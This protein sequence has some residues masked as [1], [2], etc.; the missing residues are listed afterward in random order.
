[1]VWWDPPYVKFVYINAG[2]ILTSILT[3]NIVVI[4]IG[5]GG[6]Y[7]ISSGTLNIAITLTVYGDTTLAISLQMNSYAQGLGMIILVPY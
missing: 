4:N 1:M 6:T 7:L 5:Y 2:P 3:L